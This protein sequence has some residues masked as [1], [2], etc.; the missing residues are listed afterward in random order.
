MPSDDATS[1]V[2]LAQLQ[3]RMAAAL[4]AAEPAQQG[5]AEAL[6]AG[7]QPGAAGLRVHRHTV[8]GALSQALRQSFVSVDRLVGENYF[9]RMALDYARRRP[10]RA[11]QLD[12]YGSDF[13]EFIAAYGEAQGLPYL[14]DLARFDWQIDELARTRPGDR[15]RGADGEDLGEA[16]YSGVSLLLEEGGARLRFPSSLRCHRARFPVERLREAILAED[17]AALAALDLQPAA[18]D[19]ALWRTSEGVKVQALSPAAACFLGTALLVRDGAAA[20]AAAAAALTA[21]GNHG[22]E[23]ALVDLL[24]REILTAGF[25]QIETSAPR[26]AN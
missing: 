20:L 12:V 17:T 16:A 6:F 24:T 13:P 9:D 15:A 25:V 21:S 23:S 5:L 8:L 7:A 18:H 22:G 11:P 2:P 4:L 3:T 10:P 19:Y 26:P 1:G 14:A